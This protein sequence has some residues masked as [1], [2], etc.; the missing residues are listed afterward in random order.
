MPF[1][2]LHISEMDKIHQLIQSQQ[3]WQQI[4]KEDNNHSETLLVA[5]FSEKQDIY[6]LSVACRDARGNGVVSPGIHQISIRKWAC[7]VK[8][9]IERQVWV[10]VMGVSNQGVL[11]EFQFMSNCFSYS[12]CL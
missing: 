9:I 8:I 11:K 2:L 12:P 4:P 10:G 7:N 1:C 3:I 5:L 6:N